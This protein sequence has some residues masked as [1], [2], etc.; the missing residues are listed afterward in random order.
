MKLKHEN[1][2]S[3]FAFKCNLRRYTSATWGLNPH[4][5]L[6]EPHTM[7]RLWTPEIAAHYEAG[8]DSCY[9]STSQL[10]LSTRCGLLLPKPPLT[11]QIIPP[12]VLT[13]S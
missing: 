1:L 9:W 6:M 3:N 2:L 11:T 5:V 8:L 4:V 10:N 13:L 12:G 7:S